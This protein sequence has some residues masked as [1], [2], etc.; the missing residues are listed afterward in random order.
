M[1]E[2]TTWK[3]YS[4][5]EIHWKLIE[6]TAETAKLDARDGGWVPAQAL[7][8]P[9]YC[10]LKGPLGADWGVVLNPESVKF[11]RVVF[12]HHWCGCPTNGH[13]EGTQGSSDWVLPRRAARA[14]LVPK[15]DS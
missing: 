10:N 3:R 14:A 12:E 7:F 4:P 6:A 5:S 2:R 9:Y 13:G 11:G 8:C 15:E 1:A